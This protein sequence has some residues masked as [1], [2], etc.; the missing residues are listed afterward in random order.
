MI[1]VDFEK[2]NNIAVK[3]FDR[4]SQFLHLSELEISRTGIFFPTEIFS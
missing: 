3:E 1:V 4:A 2:N